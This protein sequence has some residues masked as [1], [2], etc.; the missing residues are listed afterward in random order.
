MNERSKL[1]T[2]IYCAMLLCALLNCL[3]G[4]ASLAA[5]P[6]V[7]NALGISESMSAVLNMLFSPLVHI[8]SEIFYADRIPV[9]YPLDI[10]FKFCNFADQQYSL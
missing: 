2:K 6:V 7:L 8:L 1:F 10:C 4:Q 9:F 5:I 3:F